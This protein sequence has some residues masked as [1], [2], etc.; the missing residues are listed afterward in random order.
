MA[1]ISAN[2]QEG[3]DALRNHLIGLQNADID[4]LQANISTNISAKILA[5][6]SANISVKISGT[7]ESS[8]VLTSSLLFSHS[9]ATSGGD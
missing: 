8:L 5:N 9:P 3:W 1:M 4:R 7:N 6:I 2:S